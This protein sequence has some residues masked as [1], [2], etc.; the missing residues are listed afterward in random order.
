M[1]SIQEGFNKNGNRHDVIP[2]VDR[3]LSPKTYTLALF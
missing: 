3:V 2:A 1:Q